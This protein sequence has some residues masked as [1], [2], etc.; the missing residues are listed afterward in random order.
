VA[1]K[2]TKVTK[3]IPSLTPLQEDI[4]MDEYELWMEEADLNNTA[5]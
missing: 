4:D 1:L 3:K 5:L 2:M